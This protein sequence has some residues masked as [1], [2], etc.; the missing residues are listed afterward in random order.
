MGKLT[1]ATY[2]AI[3]CSRLCKI[4]HRRETHDVGDQGWL[5]EDVLARALLTAAQGANKIALDYALVVH[6]FPA[7]FC[8]KL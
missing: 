2:E 8:G 6:N 3:Y 7:E 5:N 1:G 4:L